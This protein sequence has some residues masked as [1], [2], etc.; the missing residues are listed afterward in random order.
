M[1]ESIKPE[2]KKET[3]TAT[4]PVTPVVP[5][6][7]PPAKSVVALAAASAKPGVAGS[8]LTQNAV[9]DRAVNDGKFYGKLYKLKDN[10]PVS[11]E[12]VV[13]F[14]MWDKNIIPTLQ[15]YYQFCKAS[16]CAKEQLLGVENLIYRANQWQQKNPKAVKIADV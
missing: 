6:T 15:K 2:E 8:G 11:M 7:Q 10:T 16:G 4:A 14:A 1:A 5:S 3:P 12:E 13:V 9:P